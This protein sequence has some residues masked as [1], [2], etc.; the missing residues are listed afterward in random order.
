MSVCCHKRRV[1]YDTA[2]ADHG[3]FGH[4]YL[5]ISSCQEIDQLQ[6]LG[7]P[8]NDSFLDAMTTMVT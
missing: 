2:A 8:K 5:V 1:I 3:F 6:P 4:V 7:K